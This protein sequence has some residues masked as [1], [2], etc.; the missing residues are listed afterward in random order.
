MDGFQKGAKNIKKLKN[1]GD[2]SYMYYVT[3]PS[4]QGPCPDI[5]LGL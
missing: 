1:G 3:L 5:V 4:G 2:M